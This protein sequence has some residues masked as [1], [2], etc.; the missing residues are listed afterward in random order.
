MKAIGTVI[1]A[2]ALLAGSGAQEQNKKE[3]DKLQ[4]TWTIQAAKVAG[5]DYP[6]KDLV[7]QTITFTGDSI[8]CKEIEGNTAKAVPDATKTP[9]V[10]RCVNKKGK[11]AR[12][13][14][15]QQDGD[16][17]RVI[18]IPAGAKQPAD[19]FAKPPVDLMVMT[20]KRK[21]K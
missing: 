21:K 16:R 15:Y 13:F 10:M 3:L 19:V 1:I 14:V 6:V 9:P 12:E 5:N 20:F 7:A 8:R 18:F 17:L 11:V 2:T 4:G